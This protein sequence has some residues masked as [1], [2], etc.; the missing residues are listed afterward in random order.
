MLLE[1]IKDYLQPFQE[2]R[3]RL[4][5]EFPD[6]KLVQFDSGKLQKLAALLRERKRGGHKV[7]IFTQMSKM[8]SFLALLSVTTTN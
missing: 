6:K 7:L 5:A 2:V 4:S 1:P 3:G 8:V